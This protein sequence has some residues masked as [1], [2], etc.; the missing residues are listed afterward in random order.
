MTE[1]ELLSFVENELQIVCLTIFVL[2]YASRLVWLFRLRAPKDLSPRKGSAGLGIAM[3]FA[4][5]AMPWAMASTRKHWTRYLEFALLHIGLG[6]A[7]LMTFVI[8]YVPQLVTREVATITAVF[9]FIGLGVGL[10]RMAWRISRPEMR[11][12][13]ITDDYFS[14]AALNVYLF[15]CAVALWTDATPWMMAYFILTGALLIYVPFSKISHYLYWPFARIF[16]G[17]HIGRRGIVRGGVKS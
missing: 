14:I 9:V 11:A 12:I 6:L 5:L 16:Y 2:L 10:S 7:I 8:P 15:V 1:K 13:S 17:L 4:M 3:A